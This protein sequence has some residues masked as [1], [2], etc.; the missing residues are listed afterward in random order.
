MALRGRK[1][2]PCSSW[3]FSRRR[4]TMDLAEYLSVL[5]GISRDFQPSKQD[6]NCLPVCTRFYQVSLGGLAKGV[7]VLDVDI[8]HLPHSS[9]FVRVRLA[10][11]VQLVS[12]RPAREWFTWWMAHTYYGGVSLSVR[13]WFLCQTGSVTG[14]VMVLSIHCGDGSHSFCP[15]SSVPLI[16]S[17]GK[18]NGMEGFVRGVGTRIH[19]TPFTDRYKL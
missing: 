2:S 17:V 8:Y 12:Q 4:F 18:N 3:F 9:L 6:S 19:P 16:T 10:L 1:Q 11:L 13:C 14:R 5:D 15:L 7:G